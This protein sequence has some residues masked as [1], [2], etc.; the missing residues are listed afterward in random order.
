MTHLKIIQVADISNIETVSAQILQKLYE[1]TSESTLDNTSDLRGHLHVSLGNRTIVEWLR[2]HFPNL[3]ID[4][5]NYAIEFEDPNM[6]AYL[7][8]TMGIG[9]TSGVITETEAAAATSVANST[10]TSITKFNELKYFTNI[11]ESRGGFNVNGSGDILFANWTALQEIDISNFTSIGHKNN[12]NMND[13][14]YGCTAIESI[15]VP[16]ISGRTTLPQAP[17]CQDCK[18]L[19]KVFINEGYAEV[20][21]HC[22]ES[23]GP[24]EEIWL[25]STFTTFGQD[26]FKNASQNNCKLILFCSAVPSITNSFPPYSV[27]YVPDDAVATYQSAWPSRASSIQPLSALAN[28][29]DDYKDV[30]VSRGCAATGST[31]NWIITPPQH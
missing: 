10:N 29:S 5:D 4:V 27:I 14:F 6:L 31:G 8:N 25:P 26:A 30:M 15:T 21:Y 24:L 19:K 28:I 23:S 18:H 20:Q 13:R 1:V 17:F 2:A 22:F 12:W 7:Q 11:T 9:A 3:T 16:Y